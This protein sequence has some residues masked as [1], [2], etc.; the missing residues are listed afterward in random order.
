MMTG[1]S[2]VEVW[3]ADMHGKGHEQKGDRPIILWRDLDHVKMAIIMPCTTT[4]DAS[5]F[6]HT[7]LISQTP[8]NGLSEDS[9]AL[10]F[11]ITSVD[12]KRLVK[13]LGELDTE[14]IAN[15]GAILK[16]MLRT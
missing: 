4:Q 13:K 7:Y 12:K 15:I 11:Q 14:D 3:I 5:K 9:I 1:S 2:K 10:I 6:P 8:K 16:E